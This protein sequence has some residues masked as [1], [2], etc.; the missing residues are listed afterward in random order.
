MRDLLI[1]MQARVEP[2]E[3]VLLTVTGLKPAAELYVLNKETKEMT[4]I[5]TFDTVAEMN[6]FAMKDLALIMA[7]FI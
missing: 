5:K 2:N 1:L 3:V 7:E 6:R 4:T